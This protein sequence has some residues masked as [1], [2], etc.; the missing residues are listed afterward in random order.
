MSFNLPEKEK[1]KREKKGV[2]DMA[3]I[4]ELISIVLYKITKKYYR[5]FYIIDRIISLVSTTIDISDI[6][7]ITYTQILISLTSFIVEITDII[8]TQIS[9]IN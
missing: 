8:D 9:L 6:T 3:K 7:N 2:S 5:F 4:K 1:T